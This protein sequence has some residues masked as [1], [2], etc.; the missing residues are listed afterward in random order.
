M[1]VDR[2]KFKELNEKFTENIKLCDGSIVS[3]Q[4]KGSILSQ[5]KNDDHQDI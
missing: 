2:V 5:C 3:I 4:G 1:T